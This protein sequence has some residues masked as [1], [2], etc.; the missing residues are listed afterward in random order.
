[1]AI[2]AED[3]HDL[4]RVGPGSIMGD[5]LREYWRP[6]LRSERLVADGAPQRVKLFGQTYVAWRAT[7]GE[8][9]FFDEGCPHRGVSLTLAHN[10]SNALRCIFHG[11]TFDITGKCVYVPTEPTDTQA[12]FAKSVK[13][14]HY[15]VREA[16]GLVW[17]YLGRE[18]TPPKF[19]D[20]EFN[21]LPADHVDV[22]V[23]VFHVN[24]LQAM[25]AVLDS[26]HLGQL[27]RTTLK[28][29][30]NRG[31]PKTTELRYNILVKSPAPRFEVIDTDYG[32]R[33]AAIRD[34]GDGTVQVN[35]RQF[36]APDLS[37]LPNGKDMYKTVCMSVPQDDEWTAQYF[38]IYRPEKP[39]T[40][41]E[42]AVQWLNAP[43]DPDD[44]R[45]DLGG[46]HNSW[47]QD[48]EAMKNGHASGF[49]GLNIFQ[50]D[51]ICQESMGPIVD[52]TKETLGTA[53]TVIVHVRNQLLAHARAFRAG[54][55]RPWGLEDPEQVQYGRIRAGNLFLEDVNQWR[56]YDP[57]TQDFAA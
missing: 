55:G 24:W 27:H 4:T 25:E 14:N 10:H 5:M 50:E 13:V 21:N 17:V 29:R 36:V 46:F 48:R 11:W 28:E 52:R 9:G 57:F 3:N 43:E 37:F 18:A 32:F 16:G 56:T 54:E 12:C 42:R 8:V 22:R 38:L 45:G 20:F 39:L 40:E 51:F 44:M 15:P 31:D 19:P 30:F 23:G 47:N 53:D 41:Q 33:E 2:S 49:P 34:L 6:A 26:A 7:N 35:L 1:M